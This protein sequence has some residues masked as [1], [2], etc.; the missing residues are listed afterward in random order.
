MQI[1]DKNIIKMIRWAS[2][3]GNICFLRSACYEIF[4]KT[5]PV[6]AGKY[7]RKWGVPVFKNVL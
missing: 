7:N 3:F 1:W 6:R 4:T 5:I 2:F